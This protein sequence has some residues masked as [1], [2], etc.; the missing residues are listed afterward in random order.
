MKALILYFSGTGNTKYIADK[1][2]SALIARG[3]DAEVHSVEETFEICPNAYDFLIL[4]CPKYYEYPV[5]FFLEYLKKRLPAA[6]KPTPALFFCTQAGN[7]NTNFKP[8]RRLLSAKNYNL[9]AEKSIPIANNLLFFGFHPTPEDVKT[10]QITAGEK[11]ANELVENLIHGAACRE[12]IHP[13]L[14]FVDHAVAAL[15]D[16]LM[17]RFFVQYSSNEDC[18]GCEYCA[19]KCPAANIEIKNH[20]P[21]FGNKCIFCTRCINA[22]PQNAILYRNR[23]FPQYR[24]S[25]K[26]K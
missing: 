16:R 5:F 25:E 17:P 11:Q 14:G 24:I 22:C 21:V 20:R 12:S 4:G 7:L 26:S 1:M 2:K 9:I 3:C 18:T 8:L 23:K 6:S 19:K 10:A 13:I 15:C